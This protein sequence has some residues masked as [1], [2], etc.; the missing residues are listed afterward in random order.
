MS[1]LHSYL[2]ASRSPRRACAARAAI[3]LVS[4]GLAL[5]CGGSTEVRL[6]EVHALHDVGEFSESIEP[7]R[8]ILA[9]EPNH[10]EASYLLG[11]ALIQTGRPSLAIW[12]LGRAAE[13][14]EFGVS[15]GLLLASTL[16]QTKTFEEAAR[17]ADRVLELEPDSVVALNL[18][19]QSNIGA[20]RNEEALA[21]SER[22]L[23]LQP[24]DYQALLLRGTALMQLDRWEEA[25]AV[26]VTLR[27][28]SKQSEDPNRAARGC[29]ALATFHQEKEPPDPTRAGAIFEECLEEFPGDALVLKLASDYYQ[30]FERADD[31]IALWRRAVEENPENYQFR[32]VLAQQLQQAGRL[33]DAAT[34]L[35][36]TAELFDNARAWS[37]LAQFRQARGELDGAE[38]AL[39]RALARTRGEPPELLFRQ[40]DLAISRGDFQAAEEIASRVDEAV[41][42]DLIRG[43]LLLA[44]GDYEK[45]YAALDSGLERWPNNAAARYLAGEAAERVGN[46]EKAL[47]HYREAVRIDESATDAAL[48]LARLNFA[49]GHH[50][51]AVGFARMQISKR[52][53]AGPEPFIVLARASA[54][55]DQLAHARSTL[56]ALAKIP[57]QAPTAMAELAAI[58]RAASG[59]QAA[60]RVIRDSGL[61][62]SDPKNQAALRSL[63]EDEVAL[64]RVDAALALVAKARQANPDAAG[65][66]DIEARV[67]LRA[68]R[69]D[70]ARAAFEVALQRDAELASALDGLGRLLGN[71][72]RVD[73]G[74]DYLDRAARA[75][76]EFDSAYAAAQLRLTQGQREDGE[77]RLREIVRANPGHAHAANDLAWLLAE[78]GKDS[79]LALELA[80]RAVRLEPRAETLDTLGWVQF[81]RGESDAAVTAL[82]RAVELAPDSASVRYRLGMALEAAGRE[83]EA[84][85]AFRQ[86]VGSGPFP[87]VE[88]ARAEIA[89]LEAGR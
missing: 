1:G 69:V 17:A 59:S 3:A 22:M 27:E 52:P 35:V 2:R 24:D 67:L 7:L 38:E 58:E 26:H 29:V 79:E 40:A 19:A 51:D 37:E 6:A 36:E 85:E 84:L 73:E 33:D 45:A 47:Q 70:E 61:D 78:Q 66:L 82:G 63:V 83:Q 43:R 34:V 68:G 42:R 86:A 14:E 28:S 15:A 49:Y 21:D 55:R 10:P 62:L 46:P 8:E 11:V 32:T 80:H 18:R 39:E 41:Y 77:R 4:L 13:S 57:E 89:R 44:Q 48:A 75:G 25:E 60:A 20:A 5:G 72:G 87:E 65:P 53:F 30:K 9:E 50:A 12:P 16:L 64:G 74:I 71:Q 76:S 56:Q 23:E 88:A 54:A 81:K 31:A